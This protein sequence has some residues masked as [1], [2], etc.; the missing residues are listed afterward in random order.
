MEGGE[1]FQRI[2]DRQDGP[3]TEREAAHIMHEICIALKYLH[4]SN[5]AHRDLKPENLLYTSPHCDATIKLTDFGFAVGMGLVST[6]IVLI[7]EFPVI[8]K[9]LTSK[10]RF[11]RLATRPTTPPPRS[12]DQKSTIR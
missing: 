9:K 8:R 5:I 12:S 2:Q 3:F 11:R 4:D 7:L 10:T 1:L 6:R